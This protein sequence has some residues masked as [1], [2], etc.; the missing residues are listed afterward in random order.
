MYLMM[1]IMMMN[2]IS[3]IVLFLVL[4][5]AAI[6]SGVASVAAASD[7]V[8]FRQQQLQALGRTSSYTSNEPR[9]L[10]KS[11]Q[12]ALTRFIR[13]SSESS[14]KKNNK[15]KGKSFE[16][17]CLAAHNAYRAMHGAPDL[18]LDAKVSK[19]FNNNAR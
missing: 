12:P 4:A 15:N 19:R 17:D 3:G 7:I 9:T 11:V 5:S 14:N 2:R 18:K 6:C 8:L 13:G 1:Q 16:L 10:V